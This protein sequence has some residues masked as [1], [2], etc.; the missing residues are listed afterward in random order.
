MRLLLHRMYA[1]VYA[2]IIYAPWG[3]A[4]WTSKRRFIFFFFLQYRTVSFFAIGQ[5]GR[6]RFPCGMYRCTVQ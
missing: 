4:G 2:T 1:L 3:K 5:Q 6:G